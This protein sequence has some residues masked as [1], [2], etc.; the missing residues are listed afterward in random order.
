MSENYKVFFK[1][2]LLT[3]KFHSIIHIHKVNKWDNC[4]CIPWLV[5]GVLEP[6]TVAAF[7]PQKTCILSLQHQPA[8]LP[9]SVLYQKGDIPLTHPT[10]RGQHTCWEDPSFLVHCHWTRMDPVVLWL[11]LTWKTTTTTIIIITKEFI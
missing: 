2:L 3:A 6:S 7:V 9:V 4:L 8:V 1:S 10:L 11:V 5:W